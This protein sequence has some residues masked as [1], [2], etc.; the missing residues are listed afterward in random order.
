MLGPIHGNRFTGEDSTGNWG[1]NYR[2]GSSVSTR[3]RR[4]RGGSRPDIR[5]YLASRPSVSTVTPAGRRPIVTVPAMARK[6]RSRSIAPRYRPLHRSPPRELE[7]GA[8]LGRQPGVN[9]QK[10]AKGSGDVR[11]REPI[12]GRIFRYLPQ[13]KPWRAASDR[14]GAPRFAFLESNA[15]SSHPNERTSVHIYAS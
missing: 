13:R 15:E 11:P 3:K 10:Y 8:M 1:R 14:R 5:S 2:P 9:S 12:T 7:S 6:A 4:W